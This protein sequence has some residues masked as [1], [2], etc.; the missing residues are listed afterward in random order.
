MLSLWGQLK[1]I[2]QPQL[3]TSAQPRSS[4]LFKDKIFS[5]FNLKLYSLQIT[6]LRKK[7]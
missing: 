5:P 4:L 2:P 7:T 6:K 3:A 1:Q